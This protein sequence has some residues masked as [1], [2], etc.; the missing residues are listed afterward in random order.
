MAKQVQT[1]TQLQ[2]CEQA[3]MT[4]FC[5]GYANALLQK[6]KKLS[7]EDRLTNSRTSSFSDMAQQVYSE[8][9]RQVGLADDGKRKENL[10]SMCAVQIAHAE[11]FLAIFEKPKSPAE[12]WD[13]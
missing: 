6:L 1:Q 8:L 9:V 12:S 2:I 5:W 3:V 4:E 11:E 10:Q 7:E 13:R